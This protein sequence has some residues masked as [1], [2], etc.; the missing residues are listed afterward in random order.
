MPLRSK[1]QLDKKSNT[2]HEGLYLGPTR[3]V[4]EKSIFTCWGLKKLST[5]KS[6]Y[7]LEV[8]PPSFILY[9]GLIVRVDHGLIIIH[10]EV[11]QLFS[12]GWMSSRDIV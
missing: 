1:R 7:T 12:K 4:V 6:I 2:V 8:Q 11:Y 10:P 5:A 9:F 3:A